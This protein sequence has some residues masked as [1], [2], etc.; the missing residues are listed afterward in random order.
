MWRLLALTSN[1]CTFVL[2]LFYFCQWDVVCPNRD[3]VRSVLC[4]YS[5]SQSRVAGAVEA[6]RGLDLLV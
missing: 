5:A 3:A 1:S 4:T 6:L 2:C